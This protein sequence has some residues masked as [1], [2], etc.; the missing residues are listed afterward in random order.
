MLIETIWDYLFYFVLDEYDLKE[1]DPQWFRKK[2]SMVGQ[3][4][5]LFAC[6]IKE[7]IAFGVDADITEVSNE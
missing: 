4:P 3:E 7:N 1:L 2:I 5:T 6:S